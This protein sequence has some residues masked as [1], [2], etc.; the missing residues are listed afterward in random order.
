[1][2][3]KIIALYALYSFAACFGME[4]SNPNNGNEEQHAS[5]AIP[6]AISTISTA[7]TCCR[8]YVLPRCTRLFENCCYCC[9][10]GDSENHIPDRTACCGCCC[11]EHPSQHFSPRNNASQWDAS[12]NNRCCGPLERRAGAI[13][14]GTMSIPT[15]LLITSWL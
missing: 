6:S 5:I 13:L 12:Y 14:C 10:C 8:Q 2:Y 3:K 11:V 7:A 9:C 4:S 1:M 15:A